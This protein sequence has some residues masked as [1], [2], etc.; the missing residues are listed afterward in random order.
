MFFIPTIL[1]GSITFSLDKNLNMITMLDGGKIYRNTICQD[2]F[3][4]YGNVVRN[5]TVCNPNSVRDYVEYYPILGFDFYISFYS[6]FWALFLILFWYNMLKKQL[7]NKELFFQ[8]YRNC[9]FV[10]HCLI[11]LKYIFFYYIVRY[12]MPEVAC[13]AA[14]P[15][16]ILDFTNLSILHK[17]TKFTINEI[18]IEI[19]DKNIVLPWSEHYNANESGYNMI[20]ITSDDED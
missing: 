6:G 2:Y 9:K 3:Y 10:L 15:N 19:T 13:S 17:N 7:K 4:N 11:C 1:L 8:K 16:M 18:N 14:L 20:E 12:D 5:E